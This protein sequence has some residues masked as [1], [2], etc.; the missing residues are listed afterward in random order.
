MSNAATVSTLYVVK[1]GDT[2]TKIARE[3]YGDESRAAEIA[4]ANGKNVNDILAVGLRLKLPN[5]TAVTVADDGL[6]EVTVTAPELTFW[7][8]Y[9]KLILAG[10]LGLALVVYLARQKK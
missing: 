1:L 10:G 6:E 9:W 7:Q 4:S 8:R 5:T 2:L 3:Q